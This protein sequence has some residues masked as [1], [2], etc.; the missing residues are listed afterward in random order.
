VEKG[1]KL[2]LLKSVLPANHTNSNAYGRVY[3]PS[4][5]SSFVAKCTVVKQFILWGRRRYR[6]L[7]R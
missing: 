4:V 3:C 6:W 7:Q 2:G 1:L 5:C